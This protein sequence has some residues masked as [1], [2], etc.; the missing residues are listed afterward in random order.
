[1]QLFSF[2]NGAF[3][4]SNVRFSVSGKMLYI[5]IRPN[6]AI[7]QLNNE[8]PGSDKNVSTL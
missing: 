8:I 7:M 4:S 5:K 2:M 6:A 3:T 1:M